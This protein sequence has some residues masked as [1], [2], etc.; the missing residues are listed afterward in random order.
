MHMY[1]AHA[2]IHIQVRARLGK[3]EQV[4]HARLMLVHAAVAAAAA[5]LAA[6][7]ATTAAADAC[8]S[9]ATCPRC[10]AA[11]G[12]L[13]APLLAIRA[14]GHSHRTTARTILS[15]VT[16]SDAPAAPTLCPTRPPAGPYTGRLETFYAG[17][18]R[19]QSSA[20]GRL[21]ASQGLVGSLYS[22]SGGA[23]EARCRYARAPAL[24]RRDTALCSDATPRYA[25]MRHSVMQ[26]CDTAICSDATQRYA[27]M[28]HRGASCAVSVTLQASSAAAKGMWGTICDDGFDSRDAYVACRQLGLGASPDASPRPMRACPSLS[29]PADK[30]DLPASAHAVFAHTALLFTPSVHAIYWPARQSIRIAYCGY[31]RPSC[32]CMQSLH[33]APRLCT[34]RMHAIPCPA[35][36]RYRMSTSLRPGRA[37]RV[38]TPGDEPDDESELTPSV[39]RNVPTVQVGI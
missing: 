37:I 9:A 1:Y 23:D 39:S 30:T 26:R 12:T 29:V 28:R 19:A 34:S 25:A 3:L 15:F 36:P 22:A 35:R 33:A 32:V 17:R 20:L 14:R 8:A 6:A 7:A 18:W 24:Q 2:H 27:A 5:T 11:V 16:W 21:Y 10:G 13:H 38:W 31:D 4:P